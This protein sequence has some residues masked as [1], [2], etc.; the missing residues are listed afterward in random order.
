METNERLPRMTVDSNDLLLEQVAQA[1]QMSEEER[2]R[3]GG[4][5]F[6]FA[7][8]AARSGIAVALQTADPERIEAR[9]RER[10][11]LGELLDGRVPQ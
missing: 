5:L 8:E 11:K 10:L 7:C 2:F 1:L 4:D 6:D 9:L 3:A